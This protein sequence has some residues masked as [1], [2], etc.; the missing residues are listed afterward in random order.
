MP[1]L[2]ISYFFCLNIQ[3]KWLLLIMMHLCHMLSIIVDITIRF[4]LNFVQL[5]VG[6]NVNL[7]GLKT[8][9][10]QLDHVDECK[11]A[12]LYDKYFDD[13]YLSLHTLKRRLVTVLKICWS[14]SNE[15]INIIH[16]CKWRRRYVLLRTAT[17]LLSIRAAK[18]RWKSPSNSFLSIAKYMLD[19]MK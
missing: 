16:W 19:E 15:T 7:I 1:P 4:R 14:F 8:E 17:H 2:W 6:S 3:T 11:H 5:I 13:Q 10:K 12:H 18:N 9:R